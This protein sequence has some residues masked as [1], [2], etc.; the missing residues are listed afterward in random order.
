MVAGGVLCGP[1]GCSGGL[2]IFLIRGGGLLIDREG[3]RGCF[4]KNGGC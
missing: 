2:G 4:L 1:G 3:L